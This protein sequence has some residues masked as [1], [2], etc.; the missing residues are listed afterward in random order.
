MLGFLSRFVDSN[1]REL[2]RIQPIVDEANALEPE[3]EALSDALIRARIDAIRDE[4]REVAK[5]LEPSEDELHHPD[6]ERRR[7]LAKE[8]HTKQLAE[9]GAA[10]DDVVPEVLAATR[11]AMKR[12]L[13]MRHFDVQLTGAYVLHHG[14]IAEMKTGEGKTFVATPA[15]ILNSLTGR[16]VHVVTIND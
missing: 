16:G 9:I 15:A 5:E 10:L 11:E 13:G 2:K 1:E 7:E 12:A 8:R 4:I 6:L 3:F 14:Q